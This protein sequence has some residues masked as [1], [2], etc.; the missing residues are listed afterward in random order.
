MTSHRRQW[1][2]PILLDRRRILGEESAFSA[3]IAKD[4]ISSLAKQIICSTLV[5]TLKLEG[6][7]NYTGACYDLDSVC[8]R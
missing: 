6:C 4:K 5:C 7:C 3:D 8:E 2:L 1:E